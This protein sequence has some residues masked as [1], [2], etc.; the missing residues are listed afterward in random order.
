M[1]T[2]SMRKNARFQSVDGPVHGNGE[3]VPFQVLSILTPS[4][5]FRVFP[6]SVLFYSAPFCFMR[7]GSEVAASA[8]VLK[9][10]CDREA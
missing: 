1:G 3:S 10:I 7:I 2:Y 5:P 4:I 9:S 8:S 6:V